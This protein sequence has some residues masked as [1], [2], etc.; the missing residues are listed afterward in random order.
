MRTARSGRSFETAAT[1]DPLNPM[2]WNEIG[3]VHVMWADQVLAQ[4]NSTT[5]KSIRDAGK[6][7]ADQELRLAEEALNKAIAMKPDYAPAHYHLGII[8]D[9]QN[10]LKDAI[11]KLEQVLRA[12]PKDVGVGFQLAVLYYR[13]NDK[14]EKAKSKDL[15]EQIV[16]FQ[17]SY[18]NARWYLATVYQELG[19]Y[20]DELLQLQAIQDQVGQNQQVAD[21]ISSVKK[22]RDAKAKPST[23]LLPEPI[24]AKVK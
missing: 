24:S 10:K 23:Q 19:R 21:K 4:A 11:V 18:V 5:T 17:P 6:T 20:D 13:D 7:I 3:K 16:A 14:G 2:I 9:R 1:L 8:Y 15:L 12:N 22:L